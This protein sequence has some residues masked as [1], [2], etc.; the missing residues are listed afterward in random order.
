MTGV[1]PRFYKINITT[2]F[3]NAVNATLPALEPVVVE[4]FTPP[5]PDPENFDFDGMVPLN[6]RWICLQ[7]FEALRLRLL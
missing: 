2:N 6:N 1:A 7:V 3:L 4:R 5:V